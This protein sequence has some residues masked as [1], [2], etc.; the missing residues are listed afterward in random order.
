MC[1]FT[2]CI[3]F[4]WI[5]CLLQYHVLHYVTYPHGL[6]MVSLFILIFV[7]I[8]W[9]EPIFFCSLPLY[10]VYMFFSQWFDFFLSSTKWL[11][12]LTQTMWWVSNFPHY[13]VKYI[14]WKGSQSHMIIYNLFRHKR[15]T[16]TSNPITATHESRFFI[17]NMIKRFHTIFSYFVI[18]TWIFGLY[19][20]PPTHPPLI[21]TRI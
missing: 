15:W 21:S 12:F 5:K 6:K 10:C 7:L 13:K 16:R 19:V 1:Q 2:N 18:L 14:K 17:F 20:A 4:L 3:H 9:L 11:K 8:V